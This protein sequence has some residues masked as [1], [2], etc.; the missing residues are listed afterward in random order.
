MMI[1]TRHTGLTLTEIIVAVAIIALLAAGLYSVSNYIE[2]QAK[3]KLTE[4]TIEAVC[5]AIEQYYDFYGSFPFQAGI[6]YGRIQLEG[7]DA[8]GL[9]GTVRGDNKCTL[10]VSD[11]NGIYASGDALYYF[12]NQIPASRK[13]LDE[14]NRSMVTNKDYKGKDY[15]FSSN[16]DSQCYP[17]IHIIDAWKC[18]L[19]YTYKQGDNFPLIESAGP[20]RKFNTPDD[21]SSKK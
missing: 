3:I 2:K 6:D 15:Y 20:D 1:K 14:I 8:N 5:A 18:P 13:I 4:S 11:Y 19:R 7:T 12:L 17:L 9:N 21:I 16:I 10:A